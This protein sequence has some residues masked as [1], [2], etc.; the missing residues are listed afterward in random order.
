MPA[1]IKVTKVFPTAEYQVTGQMFVMP[2]RGKRDQSPLPKFCKGSNC[3]QGTNVNERQVTSTLS[4]YK[5]RS[6]TC[7]G[8][9]Q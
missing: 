4:S 9:E 7:H 5:L 1:E 2:A 8:D 3:K 6:A